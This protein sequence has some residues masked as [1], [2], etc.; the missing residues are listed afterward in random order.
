MYDTNNSSFHDHDNA[1]GHDEFQLPEPLEY[2]SL[3][4]FDD[5]VGYRG[6][7]S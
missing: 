3:D 5:L 4:D 1:P 2:W 7:L 6:A